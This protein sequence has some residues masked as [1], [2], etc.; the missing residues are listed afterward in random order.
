MLIGSNAIHHSHLPLIPVQAL[1]PRTLTPSPPS[2]SMENKITIT[3][4]ITITIV[5]TMNSPISPKIPPSYLPANQFRWPRVFSCD[6]KRFL[7]CTRMVRQGSSKVTIA[8]NPEGDMRSII[9]VR[10]SLLATQPAPL[11]VKMNMRTYIYIRM[12]MRSW[13]KMEK[14]GRKSREEAEKKGL[15][16]NIR[17]AITNR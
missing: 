15:R 17:W 5:K 3:Q 4:K 2:K 16:M 6:P 7:T 12:D 13:M 8:M 10:G 1:L 9:A 14:E 11:Q